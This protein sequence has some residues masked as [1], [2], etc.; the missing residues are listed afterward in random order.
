MP[1]IAL[2]RDV[3][4]CVHGRGR[5]GAQIAGGHP[6]A[7]PRPRQPLFA[8]PALTERERERE[9]LK[10]L[11]GVNIL[12]DA[13]TVPTVCFSG[14]LWPEASAPICSVMSQDLGAHLGLLQNFSP[15]TKARCPFPYVCQ[16]V[17]RPSPLAR[18][19]FSGLQ[20]EKKQKDKVLVSVSP[21]K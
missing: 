20:P 11:G 21:R 17:L 4:Q 1:G 5:P 14:A 18:T 3:L 13:V 16:V 15:K 2:S 8:V 10:V 9:G 7:L 6:Q 12:W 19:G